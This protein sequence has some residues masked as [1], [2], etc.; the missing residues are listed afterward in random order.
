MSRRALISAERVRHQDEMIRAA[1][2]SPHRQ[3]FSDWDQTQA[4]NGGSDR[5]VNECGE[6]L[7]PPS[8]YTEQDDNL[9]GVP[10]WSNDR[11]NLHPGVGGCADFIT[12][13]SGRRER[14]VIM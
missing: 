3:S 5:G 9:D 11:V 14:Y 8:P 12:D 10:V 2:N 1:G 13:S 6:S 4:S 7:S